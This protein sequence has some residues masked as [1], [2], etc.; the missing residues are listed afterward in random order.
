MK[1]KL[2]HHNAAELDF[3]G[4]AVLYAQLASSAAL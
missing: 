3:E 1:T 2:N 4:G